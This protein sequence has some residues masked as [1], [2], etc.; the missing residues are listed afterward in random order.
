MTT[1][2]CRSEGILS[3]AG[4]PMDGQRA[5]PA[6]NNPC[7]VLR[8]QMAVERFGFKPERPTAFVVARDDEPVAWTR[9]AA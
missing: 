2:R 5:V 8:H 7:C 6:R 1:G 9:T 3:A 4:F